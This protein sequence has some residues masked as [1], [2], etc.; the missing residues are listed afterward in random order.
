MKNLQL[1]HF[2]VPERRR[3]L[4]ISFKT[5]TIPKRAAKE[6]VENKMAVACNSVQPTC[7]LMSI[8]PKYLLI[9]L[10]LL[11]LLVTTEIL[12]NKKK[13]FFGCEIVSGHIQN[14]HCSSSCYFHEIQFQIRLH[15][16]NS[17]KNH[18]D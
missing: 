1:K 5:I 11:V 7:I 16:P 12:S 3:M 8:F 15:A 4:N 18:Q 9:T 10:V 14:G 2:I 6:N 13:F 17:A